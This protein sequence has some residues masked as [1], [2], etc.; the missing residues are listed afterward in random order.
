MNFMGNP[1]SFQDFS[2]DILDILPALPLPVSFTLLDARCQAIDSFGR[3]AGLFRAVSASWK[4]LTAQCLTS[5]VSR[6]RQLG[7]AKKRRAYC[8]PQGARM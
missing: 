1:S 2:F 6:F 5:L 3:Q 7:Q 8:L 4:S